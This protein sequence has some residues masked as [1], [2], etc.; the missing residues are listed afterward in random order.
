VP[1][2]GLVDAAKLVIPR[3]RVTSPGDVRKLLQA[4]EKEVPMTRTLYT[5]TATR[6]GDWWELDIEDLDG[7]FSQARRLDQAEAMA[8]DAIAVMLDVPEDSFDVKIEPALSGPAA[9]DLAAALDARRRLTEAQEEAWVATEQAMAALRDIG[10][11]VRDIEC[12]VGVS[13]QRA[14]KIVTGH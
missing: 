4:V 12:L 8:R 3:H 7:V 2:V 5:V 9:D 1:V 14:A 11:P 6:E 13:H 10:L